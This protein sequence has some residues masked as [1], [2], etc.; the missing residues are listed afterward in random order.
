MIHDESGQVGSIDAG[1]LVLVH[2]QPADTIVTFAE[3]TIRPIQHTGML[4]TAW[5]AT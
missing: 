3:A 2:D 1:D 4:N 5:G